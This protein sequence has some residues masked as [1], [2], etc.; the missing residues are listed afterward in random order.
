MG[1]VQFRN[2]DHACHESRYA[3]Y[4]ED[5]RIEE[6]LDYYIEKLHRMMGEMLQ[7]IKQG[8]VPE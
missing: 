6:E 2:A 8:A 4:V 3:R 7:R 5:S 1:K